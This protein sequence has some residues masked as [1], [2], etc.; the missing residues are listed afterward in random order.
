MIDRM[1]VLTR[2]CEKVQREDH[3]RGSMWVSWFL[4]NMVAVQRFLM[5][6]IGQVSCNHLPWLKSWIQSSDRID[7]RRQDLRQLFC[8]FFG[9]L[10][11]SYLGLDSPIRFQFQHLTSKQRWIVRFDDLLSML[12]S[13]TFQHDLKLLDLVNLF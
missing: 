2:P 3:S 12:Y 10:F 8:H 4:T 9:L 11:L 6:R 13:Y 7:E 1:G 5:R